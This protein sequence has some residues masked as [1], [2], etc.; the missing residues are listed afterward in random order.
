MGKKMTNPVSITTSASIRSFLDLNK[1]Q[2]KY[3]VLTGT[4]AGAAAGATA[5]AVLGPVGI[6]AGAVTGAVVGAFVALSM[7]GG[8]IAFDRLFRPSSP[9][10][11]AQAILNVL[12]E[13]SNELV[14]IDGIGRVPGEH[15]TIQKIVNGS[16]KP[17][18][19]DLS[20]RDLFDA[21][22]RIFGRDNSIRIFNGDFTTNIENIKNIVK[23]INDNKIEEAKNL[24]KASTNQNE[25]LKGYF[26][27]L[28]QIADNYL[29]NQMT[30]SNLAIC[31]GPALVKPPE[32]STGENVMQLAAM[33]ND[34][35]KVAEFMIEHADEIFAPS[36]NEAIA[37]Q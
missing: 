9:Q 3:I 5:G 2:D 27:L 1:H 14:K 32:A 24:I 34:I 30:P 18:Q 15:E 29:A 25:L 23:L 13:N 22:K 21:L 17:N 16:I 31:I 19:A 28:K 37:Q 11:R 6:L 7:I 26:L 4:L 36:A 10:N 33:A 35:N 12:Q 8:S 20:L